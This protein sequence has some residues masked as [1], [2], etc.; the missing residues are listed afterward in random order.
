ML[1]TANSMY[2]SVCLF[3]CSHISEIACLNFTRLSVRVACGRGSVLLRRRCNNLFISDFVDDYVSEL[4]VGWV[5]PW[6]GSGWVW[7]LQLL[8]WVGSTITKVGYRRVCGLMV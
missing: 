2:M 4:S 8:G 1:S 3:V 7:I 6:V 5:D